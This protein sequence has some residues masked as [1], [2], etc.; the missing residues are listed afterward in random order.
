M[1][2]GETRVV[3]VSGKTIVKPLPTGSLVD[4]RKGEKEAGDPTGD[5]ALNA[6][7]RWEGMANAGYLTPI[8]RFFVRNHAPTPRVDP[9]SW[10][11]RV[12]GP[13][14]GRTLELDYE[15]LTRLSGISVV[16]A[17]EC[18]GNGRAFFGER[19][20]R[21]A[22]GTPWRLGAVG[23][24]E[25][26]GVP[27]RE[28]LER[29]GLGL[30]EGWVMAE[31]LDA[32]RMRRP[33]PL[34]KAL[35]EDTILATG[36]NGQPLPPDHGFPARLVVPGWAA[37]A[38]VKWV[39]RIVVSDRPLFSPWNTAKYVMTGG[40]WGSRREP[41]SVQVPKS[42]I[43]LPWPAVL[44]RGR[45]TI[46][47]RSWSGGAAIDR[48]EYAVDGDTRWRPARIEGPNLPGAWARWSFQWYAR[49]GTHELRVRATDTGGNT[50]PEAV[51]WNALGYLYGGIVGHPVEVL[52]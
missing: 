9:A 10:R 5:L 23:V 27:L 29:A 3:P 8:D 25:W 22:P 14:V 41:I 40:R 35:G 1:T 45:N 15:D 11:L 28:V 52:G 37:V 33:L 36:M 30:T 50:Q 6:E 44:R 7:M 47:G 21:E 38:S 17:L 13:G 51:A 46:T 4:Y 26:T 24:A 31:G 19:Q 32:V 20:G 43:E 2:Q 42:A 16:R 18:A 49:R 34:W 12:E 39:G 48:V